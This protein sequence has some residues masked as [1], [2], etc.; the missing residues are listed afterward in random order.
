MI[1][2]WVNL[3]PYFHSIRHLGFL[4]SRTTLFRH[5]TSLLHMWLVVG[6]ICVPI[7]F[8]ACRS[9]CCG[10]SG[11]LTDLSL[12]QAHSNLGASQ[13]YSRPRY[14]GIS[15]MAVFIMEKSAGCL[16]THSD[17]HIT[18]QAGSQ[19]FLE[20]AKNSCVNP[21]SHPW[22]PCILFWFLKDGFP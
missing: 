22:S 13:G 5:N 4:K 21:D 18:G 9:L 2:I 15:Q 17:Q 11:F 16:W 20:I 14:L 12:G 10:H 7:T 6:L 8:L 1:V 19:R 3:A